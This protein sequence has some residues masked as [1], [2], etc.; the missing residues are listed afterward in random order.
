MP[1]IARGIDTVRKFLIQ[2]LPK[3][4]AAI[5]PVFSIILRIAEAFITLAGRVASGAGII[6]GWFTRLNDATNGWAGYIAAAALAWKVLNLSFL[7]TPIGMLLALAVGVALLIDD[8]LTFREG[9]ESL[10]DWGSGFGTVMKVVTA[11]LGGVLGAVVAVKGGMMAWSAA[12]TAF[13]VVMGLA[14]GVMA[15]FNLIMAANPIALVILA[16]AALIAAGIFLVANWEDVKSWFSSF[17]DWFSGLFDGIPDMV[18]QAFSGASDAAINIFNGVK[19]WFTDFFGWIMSKFDAIKDIAGAVTGFASKATDKVS[20]VAGDAWASV[21]GVFGGGDGDVAKTFS[22]TNPSA[23]LTPSPKDA[24]AINGGQQNV[25]QETQIIV[26]GSGNAEA[27]ASAVA[28]QQ[29]RVN[30]DMARN[31]RGAAR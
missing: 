24:A 15:A 13:N 30:A 8:F 18:A 5:Q 3:I 2:N 14:K 16:I 20:S 19:E 12:T 26:Q 25:N 4:I 10:I 27:T 28:G 31:M 1:Q 11:I 9:G 6:I 21:K 29:N 17:Y 22:S 7:K 23:S